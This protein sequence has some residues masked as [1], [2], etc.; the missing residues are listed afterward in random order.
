MRE[1]PICRFLGRFLGLVIRLGYGP[2]CLYAR[3]MTRAPDDQPALDGGLEPQPQPTAGDLVAAWCAAYTMDRGAQPHKTVL[4]R[5]AG[6]CKAIGKDCQTLED[7]RIAWVAASQAGH[8]GQFD[9]VPYL[10]PAQTTRAA[11]SQRRNGVAALL[12]EEARGYAQLLADE[13]GQREA[14]HGRL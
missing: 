1:L 4:R 7:W 5:V 10:I 8:H 14:I 12:E 9:V 13:D 2:S 6:S 11:Q 3:D